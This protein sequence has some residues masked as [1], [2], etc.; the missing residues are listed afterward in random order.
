MLIGRKTQWYRPYY[1]TANNKEY[2]VNTIKFYKDNEIIVSSNS[3]WLNNKNGMDI[4]EIVLPVEEVKVRRKVKYDGEVFIISLGK[5]DYGNETI[6]DVYI[7]ADMLG[8]HFIEHKIMYNSQVRAVFEG[9]QGIYITSYVKSLNEYLN[10]IRSEYEETYKRVSDTDLSIHKAENV[11]AD[12]DRLK[13]L[14]EEFIAERKRIHDLT[15]DDVD[16]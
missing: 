2:Q 5:E 7:P 16:I 14:A 11:L 6:A 4:K 10:A 15:I 9:E 12:I 3:G 1:V 13:R 8:I